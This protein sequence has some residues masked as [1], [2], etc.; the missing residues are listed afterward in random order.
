MSLNIDLSQITGILQQLLPV[1]IQ[2]AVLG[3]VMSLVFN[4]LMPMLTQA[5]AR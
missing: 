4:T 1:V 3:L 2:V 5:L